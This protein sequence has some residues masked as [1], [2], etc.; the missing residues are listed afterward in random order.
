M[1]QELQA[2]EIPVGDKQERLSVRSARR[3]I[4]G[5]IIS[6]SVVSLLLGG[7]L[8]L[9]MDFVNLKVSG[10][11]SLRSIQGGPLAVSIFLL[12][13]GCALLLILPMLGGQRREWERIVG[14]ILGQRRRFNRMLLGSTLL[15]LSEMSLPALIGYMVEVVV[16]THRS[17]S[18]L[19][20]AVAILLLMLCLRALGGFFRQDNAQGLAYSISA[21]LRQRLYSHLQK[22]NF[23]YFD[24]ARQGDLMSTLTNDVEKLQFFLLN[25]SEDF[26]VA[27]LKVY[28]GI[29]FVIFYNWK[30]ALIIMITMPLISLLLKLAGGTLRKVNREAQE[31]IARLTTELAEG[32]N[33]IRLAQSFGLERTELSRF[34]HTN[35]EARDKLLR[36]ARIS[37]TLL[38]I[39]EAIGFVGPLVI[40]IVLCIQ[41]VNGGV[42]LSAAELLTLAGY[43]GLVANPLGK[44]SRIM[45]TLSQGEAAST[46]INSILDTHAAIHDLPDAM[47]LPETDGRIQFDKVTL[48]YGPKEGS[49]LREINLTIEPGTVTAFVGESGSGKSSLVHLVPRFYE[50]TSGRVLLDGHDVRELKLASLRRH[51]GLVSQDTILVHGTIAEN[52]AYGTP[53]ADHVEILGA[54]QSANAH[55]FI[56][57]FPDSYETMVGEK[58]VTLSGGQR[59]RIAIARALLRDPRILLLDEATSALDSVSE[60]MVQDALNKLMYGRTTLLVAHRLST[61]RHADRIVVLK[62]GRIVEQ[63]SHEELIAKGGEYGR[64][65]RLQG[66][67]KHE[68]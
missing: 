52:I 3:F 31:W 67:G 8:L 64:L 38:P 30:L 55:T 32:I 16:N 7:L 45:V 56:M 62:A 11:E 54:A 47:E 2:G 25:S 26:F 36:H 1:S 58:G 49:A 40:I 20:V 35:E 28:I 22:M 29:G 24:K 41:A 33:T 61:V 48:Q 44:V 10:M 37:A 57:E 4:A 27:P 43:G 46:R 39:V 68:G 65:V 9:F 42:D 63:G 15:V 21:Q 18:E 53:D 12:C 66:L 34:Q 60:A 14:L 51:I 17:M 59:Q 5:W 6:A 23:S 13:G 19:Y 50:V